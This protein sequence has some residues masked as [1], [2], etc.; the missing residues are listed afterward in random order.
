MRTTKNTKTVVITGASSG[1]GLGIAE[2]YLDLGANVVLNARNEAKLV[3]VSQKLGQ[4]ER[5]AVVPG[6]IGLK[7]TGQRLLAVDGG[8]AAGG[9]NKRIRP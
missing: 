8:V 7:D 6:D 9:L 2:A 3:D 5:I 4:R 1:I